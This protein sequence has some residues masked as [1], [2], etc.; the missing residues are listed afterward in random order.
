MGTLIDVLGGG[1]EAGVGAEVVT[2]SKRWANRGG[3]LGKSPSMHSPGHF[4]SHRIHISLSHPSS[5]LSY[6]NRMPVQC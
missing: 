6:A 2:G 3:L 1:R 4:V 5:V